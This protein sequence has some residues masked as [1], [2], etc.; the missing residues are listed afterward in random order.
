MQGLLCLSGAATGFETS[1]RVLTVTCYLGLVSEGS[2]DRKRHLES[3]CLCFLQQKRC[4]VRDWF[5]GSNTNFESTS[6]LGCGVRYVKGEKKESE[7]ER[8]RGRERNLA[9]VAWL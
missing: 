6:D 2:R 3:L 8:G 5:R 9:K 1:T 7:E 4:F